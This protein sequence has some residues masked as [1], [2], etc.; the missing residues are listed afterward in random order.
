MLGRLEMDV[1]ECINVYEDLISTILKDSHRSPT[2][3]T[4][5]VRARFDSAQLEAAVKTV[6][7]KRGISVDE[8]F[9]NGGIATA[10]CK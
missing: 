6:I 1:D 10:M 7:T 3:I 8:L 4:G 2:T 9:N 5:K